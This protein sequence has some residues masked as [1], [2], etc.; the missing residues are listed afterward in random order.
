MWIIKNGKN[1]F[2]I[3]S[4]NGFFKVFFFTT[5][6]FCSPIFSSKLIVIEVRNSEHFWNYRIWSGYRRLFSKIVYSSTASSVWRNSVLNYHLINVTLIVVIE[7]PFWPT[8]E[9]VSFVRYVEYKKTESPKFVCTYAQ[10]KFKRIMLFIFYWL[11]FIYDF[12]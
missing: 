3:S 2:W 10:L 11:E 4:I 9:K 8:W 5:I 1:A 7:E 12:R 6:L